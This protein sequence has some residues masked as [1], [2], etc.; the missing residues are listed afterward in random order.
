[1]CVLFTVTVY[2]FEWMCRESCCIYVSTL[3]IAESVIL[4]GVA[5]QASGHFMVD[6]TGYTVITVLQMH[7]LFSSFK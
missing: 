1:M 7:W 6:A 4:V 2:N 3:N 5:I